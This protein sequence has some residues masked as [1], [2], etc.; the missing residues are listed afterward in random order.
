MDLTNLFD[1]HSC[2]PQI[3]TDDVSHLLLRNRRNTGVEPA[4]FA[5]EL[6]KFRPHQQRLGAT[7]HHQDTIIKEL[8]S[9]WKALKDAGSRGPG[10]RK[11]DEREK[12]KAGAVKRF[13][14]A[15]DAYM[16]VRD[17]VA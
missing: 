7:V 11:W 8:T 15:R 9:L 14:R 17:G 6:E 16:E 3:Q 1:S 4:L 5:Q 10:A 2:A 12:R 13:G